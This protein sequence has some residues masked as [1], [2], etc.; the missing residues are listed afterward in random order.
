M[1]ASIDLELMRAS[2]LLESDPAAAARHA[3][4][5]LASFPGHDAA[6]LM[7]ATAC[8]RLGDAASAV[9]AI[10]S[11]AQAHPASALIR[12]EL[13][14]TYAAC[15][16]SPEAR[17]AFERAVE[18]DAA[19]ADAWRDLAAQRLL[20][21]DTASADAAYSAYDRLTA[22]PAE[23]MDAHVALVSGRW[24]AAE[25]LVLQRLRDAPEDVRALR[26]LAEI[27]LQ[28]GDEA[29][30]EAVLNEVLQLAPCSSAAREQLTRLLMRQ[31]RIEEALPSIERLL[32]AAPSNVAV[33]L[34]QAEAL[35]LGGR[36][37]EGLAIVMGLIADQPRHPEFW[38]IAGNQQRFIG[39]PELAIEAYQR[40]ILLR[41]G[42]GEAYWAL[43]NLKTF[44]FTAEDVGNM[45]RHLSSVPPSGP[46]GTYLPFALGKALED[47]QQFAAAFE[48]YAQ[49]NIRA[50]SA[51]GYDAKAT[52]AFVRRFKATFTADFF[53]ERAGWGGQEADPIFIVGLPRS[54]ST[55]LEQILATH[56]EVEGTREL[57]HILASS[58]ELARSAIASRVPYPD[59]MAS[60]GKSDIESLAARYM[61]DTRKY[62]PR[63]APRFVDKMLGNFVSIGLIHLM[64]PRAAIIDSR[65]HPMACGFS[66]YKQL[67][68]PGMNFAYD[69]TE[70]GLYIRD[71]ADL[72]AHMDA[73]LP[74]R[75]HRAHHESLVADTEGEVRRLLDYCGL[76]FEAECLRYHENGRVAQTV[77]SEQVRR[78]INA[79]GVDQ[80]RHFETWLGP[81]RTA[82][83]EPAETSPS[84]PR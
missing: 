23:L 38:L 41:P 19:L 17:E 39:N 78:P 11:L 56:S 67:F 80:W 28:R 51:F 29:L 27:V 66:C 72:M 31:G 10:E 1:G 71:Y 43:S 64:F 54:G 3:A 25:G 12:M 63:G 14:R 24:D 5:I 32:G 2:T 84:S 79:D 9:G 50:R 40:A 77:S 46:D 34:L 81:L 36:H 75:V 15:G 55:L 47:R 21:G 16:R 59:N 45:Q 37:R 49:G 8:R 83:D 82:L 52:T 70:L 44:R 61:S 53:A 48:Q 33:L 68:N 30:A 69:L 6:N 62:R 76:P 74:G 18:L 57:P 13:G 20:A 73:A 22:P 35:R 26:L 4:A 60:L 58:R 42:Y 7:F 65:R